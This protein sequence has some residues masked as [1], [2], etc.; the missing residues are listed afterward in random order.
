MRA[1]DVLR[2]VRDGEA[3]PAEALREFILGISRGDILSQR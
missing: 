1:V 3:L 2:A